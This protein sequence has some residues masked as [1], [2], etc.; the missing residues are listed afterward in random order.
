MT[1]HNERPI[2]V[3]DGFNVFLRHY[4]VNQEVNSRSQPVGG[5]VGF[6]KHID[7]LVTTFSPEKVFVVWEN[8]GPCPRRK[9]ILPSYKANRAK[10]KE[11]KNIQAGKAGSIKDAL[12]LDDETRIQQLT[13]LAQVLK[14]TPICQVFVPETECDDVIAYMVKTKFAKLKNKKFIVSN[15]K[16]F[17]Q[18]LDDPNV[19][20]YDPATRSLVDG[21]KVQEKFGV[22]ARN[23][24]IA[25]TLAGDNSDNIDGV[26]GVGFTTAAKRFPSLSSEDMDVDIAQVIKEATEANR[27][28]KKPPKVYADVMSS[29]K[30]LRRNWEL[31]YLSDSNLSASQIA[32]VD[33]ILESHEPRMDKLALIKSITEAG[34]NSSFDFDRF[35]SQLRNFIR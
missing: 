20:I 7:H 19:N 13:I 11:V 26:P 35:S 18:L 1:R 8:G 32:K 29:E 25:K 14:A 21:K 30:L 24:C 2:I 9:R 15:D 31:M 12:A 5:V 6:L 4:F 27:G 17:Y 34:I 16:D 23:F 3:L 22:S 33:F 28:T 10:I